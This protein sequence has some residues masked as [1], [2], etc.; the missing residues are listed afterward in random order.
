MPVEDFLMPGE[1]VHFRVPDIKYGDRDY[2]LIIT[3]KRVILYA[4]RGL[5]FKKDDFI[6]MKM[7]DIQNIMY[8]EEGLI[9]KK[10]VLLIDLYDRRISLYGSAGAMKAAYQNIMNWWNQ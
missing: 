10:G 1:T 3:N 4:R 7:T 8:R 6:A 5:I 9:S 2:E